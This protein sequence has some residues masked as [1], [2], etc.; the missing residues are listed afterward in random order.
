MKDII[1][2]NENGCW[3]SEAVQ[4]TGNQIVIHLEF[5]ESS[6]HRGVSLSQSITGDKFA[7]FCSESY[8]SSVWEKNITGGI[9]GQYIKIRCTVEPIIAKYLE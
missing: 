4:L 2:Q 9:S 1:F 5:P 7:P 3:V 8:V 6:K